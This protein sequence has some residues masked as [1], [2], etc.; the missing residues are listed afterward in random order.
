MPLDVG[1]INSLSQPSVIATERMAQVNKTDNSSQLAANQLSLRPKQPE[2]QIKVR[3]MQNNKSENAGAESQSISKDELIKAVESA[4]EKMKARSSNL[5]FTIDEST[6]RIVAKIV[7][8]ETQEVIREIPPKSFLEF[9]KKF[10]ELRSL[11]F[12]K[13]V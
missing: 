9:V 12:E 3:S 11:L 6:D 5:V 7:D 4:N 2:T 1:A 10:D 8:S 13:K